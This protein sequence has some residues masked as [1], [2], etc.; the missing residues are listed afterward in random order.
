MYLLGCKVSLKKFKKEFGDK[1]LDNNQY[2]FSY[3]DKEKPF[4]C[5]IKTER[6]NHNYQLALEYLSSLYIISKCK[7]F[8]GGLCAGTIVAWIMQ[9][10]WQNMYIWKLGYYGISLLDKLFSKTTEYK[11]GKDYVLCQF[12]GMKFRTKLKKI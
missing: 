5:D 1:L 8:V 12:L 10:S 4:L 2:R 11:D 3:S 7:Y 9:N 6:P